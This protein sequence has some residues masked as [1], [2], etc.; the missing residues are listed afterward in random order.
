MTLR[1][2]LQTRFAAAVR[3]NRPVAV[4]C[5]ALTT[6]ACLEVPLWA[7]ESGML[8]PHDRGVRLLLHGPVRLVGG[9]RDVARLVTV[10]SGVLLVTEMRRQWQEYAENLLA[11]DT[12]QL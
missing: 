5:V 10:A 6:L 7:Y 1:M 9:I 4:F 12:Q 11:A 3:Q 2:T 8:G